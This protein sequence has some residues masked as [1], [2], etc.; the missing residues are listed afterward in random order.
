[1]AHTKTYYGAHSHRTLN[2]AGYTRVHNIIP[3][4]QHDNAQPNRLPEGRLKCTTNAL[5]LWK[6]PLE[7]LQTVEALQST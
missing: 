3:L 1:M 7:S 2:F 4:S 6:H 5:A